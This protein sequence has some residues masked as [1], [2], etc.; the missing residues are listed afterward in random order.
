[1]M[2]PRGYHQVPPFAR[3]LS[4]LSWCGVPV[5]FRFVKA[6]TVGGWILLGLEAAFVCI[7]FLQR[8]MGDDAAGRGMAT[9]FAIVLAPIVLLAGGLLFWGTRRGGPSVAF[10]TGAFIVYTPVM[11]GAYSFV[12]G[13]LHQID[14]AM[15]RAQFGKFDGAPALT[16]M[17]R[18]I[19]R[20]DVPELQRLMAEG[21]VDFAARDRR[22][23][24]I[25]GHAIEHALKMYDKGPHAVEQVRLLLAAGAK[26][27]ENAIAPERTS[28][29]PEG[30]LLLI[31]VIGGRSDD[32]RALLDLLLSA[33]LSPDGVDMDG[34][35]VLF[36]TYIDKDEVEILMRHGVNLQVRDTRTDHPGWSVLMNAANLEDWD[37]AQCF[38]DHG[39]AADYVA[40]DGQS[41]LSIIEEKTSSGTSMGEGF[42]PLLAAA[43]K[44]T[45]GGS[46]TAP[47]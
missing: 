12:D 13:T 3:S 18:A 29:E 27:I 47:R 14:Q 33:G 43:R 23:R 40:P 20:E 16:R 38:L 46:E 22:G 6:L 17:A 7:L 35:S 37:L 31:T 24:T 1:M 32:Q 45:A 28:A 8:N 2:E 15:G 4:S 11:F 5:R 10:W 36:S 41:L 19:D 44:A 26:P 25:L 39:V 34:R 30:H 21:P 42:E 9:G